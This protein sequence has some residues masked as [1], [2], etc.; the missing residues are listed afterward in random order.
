MR[1]RDHVECTHSSVHGRRSRRSRE[2]TTDEGGTSL[3]FVVL[4]AYTYDDCS[5]QS[6]TRGEARGLGAGRGAIYV[7]H[8]PHGFFEEQ[9]KKFFSQ[10]GQVTRVRLARSKK[11]NFENSNCVIF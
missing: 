3:C 2:K 8:I 1:S 6:V 9:M 11:A 10:F 7:G 4:V 5:S